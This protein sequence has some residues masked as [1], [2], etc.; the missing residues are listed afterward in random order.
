EIDALGGVMGE[1]ID[2]ADIQM[3]MLNTRK[4]P[5]VRALRAQA[6][7]PDYIQKMKQILENEDNLTLRPG[8]VDELIVEDGVCKGV[9]TETTA[10]YYAEAVIVTTGTFMR[11]KVLMGDLEYESGPNNQRASVKLSEN[12]E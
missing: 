11:G 6:D 7:K 3:R 2:Q 12:L 8:M 9:I 10:A 5:A 1:V 4:G